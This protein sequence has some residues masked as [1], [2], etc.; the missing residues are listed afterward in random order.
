MVSR[1][2]PIVT[3]ARGL[4]GLHLL[5]IDGI[6]DDS[7]YLP[8]RDTLIEAALAEPLAVVVDVTGLRVPAASAWSVF[9]SARWHVSMW[10]DVPLVLVCRHIHGRQ[11]LVSNGVTRRVPVFPTVAS[12][13][14]A[15]LRNPHTPRRQ[16]LR[17][18][19][20][21]VHSSLRRA[22]ELVTGCLVSWSRA[23]LVAAAS[24]AADI[25][26]EN[27]LEHTN[28]PPGLLIE[29]HDDTVTVAVHDDSKVPAVR[30]ESSDRRGDVVSGLAVLAAISRSWGNAPTPDGKTVWALIGPDECI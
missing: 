26:V 16:R 7:T 2:G 3:S 30:H 11:I 20:P 17:T 18:E 5:E 8:L 28:S 25:L 15:V 14:R 13:Y 19:L 4:D 6:L 29:G 1:D 10:P 12:A 24:L 27:V 9:S 23:E 22:R 21:A